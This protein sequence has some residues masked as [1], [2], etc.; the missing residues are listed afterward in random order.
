MGFDLALGTDFWQTKACSK[1]SLEV[2]G[3]GQQRLRCFFGGGGGGSEF[4]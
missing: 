2:P 1:V 4:M 3:M